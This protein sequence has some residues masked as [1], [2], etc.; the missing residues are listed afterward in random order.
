MEEVVPAK[1]PQYLASLRQQ[2]YYL[3]GLEQ[4]SQSHPLQN[5]EYPQ[6]GGKVALLIGEEKRGIPAH[7]INALDSTI[8]IPQTGLTRSL[9]VH[10][11]TAISV[12]EFT[13]QAL[14]QKAGARSKI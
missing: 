9:N 12:W 13:R 4:T 8:E 11:S 1:L 10:V 14:N 7:L 3:V 5:F 2:G 6:G